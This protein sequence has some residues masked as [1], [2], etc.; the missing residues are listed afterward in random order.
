MLGLLKENCKA[1]YKPVRKA[2][3]HYLSVLDPRHLTAPYSF[4][5]V[6]SSVI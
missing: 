1:G 3:R 6:R 2:R 4:A 5:V